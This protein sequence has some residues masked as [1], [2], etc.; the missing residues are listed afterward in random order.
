MRIEFQIRIVFS[1]NIETP[2]QYKHLMY[3]WQRTSKG[4]K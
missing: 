1:N 4:T 3:Q 2:V